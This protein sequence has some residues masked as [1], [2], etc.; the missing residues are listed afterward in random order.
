MKLM[1]SE[2]QQMVTHRKQRG[3]KT[4]GEYITEELWD[5]SRELQ[6][7]RGSIRKAFHLSFMQI[8]QQG[9]DA[10]REPQSALFG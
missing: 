5:S 10:V 4:K 7:V 8:V 1:E 2:S 3:K 6:N 9:T